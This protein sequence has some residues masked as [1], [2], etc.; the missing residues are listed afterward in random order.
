[1]K[2]TPVVIM[3][4]QILETFDLFNNRTKE[5]QNI[6]Q[7]VLESTIVIFRGVHENM[8]HDHFVQKE[9][10]TQQPMFAVIGYSAPQWDEKIAKKRPFEIVLLPSR[11]E[12][13]KAGQKGRRLNLGSSSFHQSLTAARVWS[14]QACQ[15]VQKR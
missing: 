8:E 9:A 15:V 7:I 13:E 5:L 4:L 1:M 6:S 14:M 12:T 3:I 11:N 10:L 2:V